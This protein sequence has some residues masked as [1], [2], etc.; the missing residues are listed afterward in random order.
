MAS[1]T[2]IPFFL[3]SR[4]IPKPGRPSLPSQVLRRIPGNQLITRRPAST[5]SNKPRVLE[6]PDKFRPPSH[7]AR[8]VLSPNAQPRN[9]P[10]PPLSAKELEEQKTKKYPNMFPPEGTVMHKFLTNRGIHVWISLG[11]LVSLATFTFSSNFKAT[12]PF[13]HLLP[14]WSQLLFHPIDTI[15]QFLTVLKMHSDH[16]TLQ[17][18]EKRKRNVDDVQK[19]REFRIAHGMEEGEPVSG[20]GTV[21]AKQGG[22]DV[23]DEKQDMYMSWD[24]EKKPVKKW[25]GIW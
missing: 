8:R 11:V 4:A 5:S 10:G 24:G 7:P 3:V 2:S 25:L 22:N 17:T 1:T 13:A 18:V 6:K 23:G 12:S 21:E 20:E 15:G 19:R 9:Y 14:P 16:I